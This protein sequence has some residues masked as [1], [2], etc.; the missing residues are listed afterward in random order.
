MNKP[1]PMRKYVVPEL[2]FGEGAANLVGRYAK[3]FESSRVFIVTDPGV[4]DAG[5]ADLVAD[6]IGREGLKSFVFAGVSPNP[7]IREVESGTQAFLSSRCDVI[8]SVGGGSPMDAAKAIAALAA[9]DGNIRSFE[10]VD[11]IPFPTA[12]MIM[13]PTTSGTGSEVSR[14]AIVNDE[15]RGVKMAIVSPKVVPDVALVD[16]RFLA[17]MPSELAAATGLDALTHATEAYVST[18]SSRLTDLDARAAARLVAENLKVLYD[19]PEDPEAQGSMALASLMAGRAFSNA[20]LGVIHAMAHALGGLLDAPHGLC[21]ALLLDGGISANRDLV[22][23]RYADLAKDLGAGEEEFA[24]DRASTVLIRRIQAL[25]RAV[26]IS[27][28]LTDLG[29]KRED[30]PRLAEFASKDACLETNPRKL[31]TQELEE[32]YVRAL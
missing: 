31:S 12:P 9:N 29:V 20:G 6:S 24:H 16:P 19:N 27:S 4:A 17:T 2:V 25:R 8:V 26:G 10:G 32:L 15:S 1:F 23:N 11:R 22:G 7:R 28:T 21:N 3:S 5:W 30:V 13:L 14:F 18:A